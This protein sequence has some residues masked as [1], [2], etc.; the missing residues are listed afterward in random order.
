VKTLRLHSASPWFLVLCV[1]FAAL[2][3]PLG[4]MRLLQ[5]GDPLSAA[6]G[7][8]NGVLLALVAPLIRAQRLEVDDEGLT[9]PAGYRPARVTWTHLRRAEL[10]WSVPG[11]AGGRRVLRLERHDDG[12]LVTGVPMGL[13]LRSRTRRARLEAALRE[14]AAAHGFELEVTDG[15]P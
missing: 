6:L 2:A 12:P 7:L 5:G 15:R 11:A 13:R 14:R 4:T 1:V 8:T 10:D 9:V 3:I